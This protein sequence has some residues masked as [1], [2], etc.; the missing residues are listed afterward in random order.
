MHLQVEIEGQLL[1]LLPSRGV[2]VPEHNTLLIADTHF[3]KE[4]T[5]RRHQIPVP[6]GATCTTLAAILTMLHDTGA[7]RLIFLGDFFHTSCSK[8]PDV[9]HAMDAFFANHPSVSMQLTLGNHDRRIGELPASW[10]L[11]IEQQIQ[12]GD[13]QLAHH[14]Q[15]PSAGSRLV[16]CGHIHPAFRPRRT[17]D[18]PPKLP[19]FWLTERQL[20]LPAIGDFTGTQMIQRGSGDQVWVCAED[21]VL[22]IR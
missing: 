18:Q 5:F 6:G 22:A 11:Q 17:I 3:G 10:S 4:A 16:C 14:P 9:M 19:C 12:L 21:Q 20:V 2:Y 13:L 1:H 15:T 7:R 8:S